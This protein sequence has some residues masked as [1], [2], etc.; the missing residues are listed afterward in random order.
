MLAPVE[1]LALVDAA[2][3]VFLGQHFGGGGFDAP[4]NRS[5][6]DQ[7]REPAAR[8][9]PHV[10]TGSDCHGARPPLFFFVLRHITQAAPGGTMGF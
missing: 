6:H 2:I 7:G 8:C 9:P 4:E 3:V 10:N 1:E 5:R